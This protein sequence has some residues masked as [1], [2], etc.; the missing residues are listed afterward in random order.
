MLESFGVMNAGL[1]A[2][3]ALALVLVLAPG[4]NSIFVFKTSIQY[5]SKPA[6]HAALAVFL[7]DAAL[8][9]LAYLGVAAA[10][11]SHPMLFAAV[12]IAGAAY[13]A[14]LG[15]SVL[16]STYRGKKAG[17]AKPET[18]PDSVKPF[19]TALVLSLTNP[20]AILFYVAFFSQFINPGF[21]RT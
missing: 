8:I 7:G 18:L 10:L 4:P 9:F 20:K 15:L 12:R 13:L 5:G 21:D 3:G 17:N 14:Y 19:R 1:Y 11:A 6:F 16:I 2:L